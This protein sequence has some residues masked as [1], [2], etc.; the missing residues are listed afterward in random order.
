MRNL[1]GRFQAYWLADASFV[2]LQ[3]MLITA[4]FVLPVIMAVSDRGVLLFN[5]ILLLSLQ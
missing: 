2:T 4:V 1:I 5:I 3:I